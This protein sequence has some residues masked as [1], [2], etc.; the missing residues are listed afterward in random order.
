M[1]NEAK[2]SPNTYHKNSN[3]E[4]SIRGDVTVG[5]ASTSTE[6]SKI[7]EPIIP[8]SAGSSDHTFTKKEIQT[9]GVK[10]GH[11]LPHQNQTSKVENIKGLRNKEEAANLLSRPANDQENLPKAGESNQAKPQRPSNPFFKSS[12]K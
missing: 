12:V 8:S 10:L 7:S 2:E 4:L 6:R 11:E 1:L 3:G 9:E 5:K